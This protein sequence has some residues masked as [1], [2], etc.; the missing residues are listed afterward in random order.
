MSPEATST[1]RVG[2]PGKRVACGSNVGTDRVTTFAGTEEERDVY[3]Y[4]STRDYKI[5]DEEVE[6]EDLEPEDEDLEPGDENME[7]EDEAMEEEEET[8]NNIPVVEDDKETAP[9]NAARPQVF[10]EFNEVRRCHDSSL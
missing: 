2:L 9:G 7:P 6:D 1:K 3:E 10:L 5:E 4:A 8:P